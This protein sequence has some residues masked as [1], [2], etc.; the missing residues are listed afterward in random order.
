MHALGPETHSI[1]AW[2]LGLRSGTSK[3]LQKPP[4]TSKDLGA[5]FCENLKNSKDLII[6]TEATTVR[7]SHWQNSYV[8]EEQ[9]STSQ[10][11]IV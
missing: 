10:I 5:R 2:I 4:K 11:Y 1:W 9:S 7:A 3:D 6:Q 8:L